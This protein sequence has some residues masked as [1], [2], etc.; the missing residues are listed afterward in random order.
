MRRTLLIIVAAATLAATG[1]A[2]HA[3]TTHSTPAAPQPADPLI[4]SAALTAQLAQARHTAAGRLTTTTDNPTLAT[5][6]ARAR[7]GAC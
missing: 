4:A 3:T 1:W 7:L 2:A 5:Q 6:L